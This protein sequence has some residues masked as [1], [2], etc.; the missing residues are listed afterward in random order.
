MFDNAGGFDSAVGLLDV[1]PVPD[2]VP[3]RLFDPPPSFGNCDPSG[4]L[5]LELDTGTADP[6]WLSDG[7][8]VEAIVG[9]DRVA[10]WAAARQARLL[11]E[12]A[13]R[14]PPDR[15]VGVA[16]TAGVASEFAPDEVGVAL[17][18]SRGTAGARIDQAVR[19][20]ST[21]P[22]THAAWEA[23]RIDT[24]K[25]RAIHDATVVVPDELAVAVEARVLPR[26]PGQ[27]LAQ[28]KAALG[29]AVPSVD[30][31]GADDRHREARRDRRV[32]VSPEP[33]GMASLWALLPATDAAG[34]FTWLTRLA[35]GLGADDP[36]CVDARRA[37]ILAALL[38]GRLVA[39]P[40]RPCEPGTS[41]APRESDEPGG[42][43]E[44]G[45]PITPV[46][47]G[48]P[49]IQVVIDHDTLL[50]AAERP[51]ELVGYGPIPA[52]L[53][54]EAAAADGLWRRLAVDPL[55]GTAL[56][57]GRTTYHPPAALADFV[58]VR[59]LTCRFP[60]CRRSARDAEL[61]HARAWTDG[62]ETSAANLHALCLH[63]HLLKHHA[64]WRITTHAD[65][66]LTWTTPTGLEHTT[67]PHDY[68]F[69]APPIPIVP[70]ACGPARDDTDPD[71]PPF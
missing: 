34:A 4:F 30:P 18:L 19:L 68:Q 1:A 5:A 31:Q 6:A 44:S 46:T 70:P 66:R 71:P 53:A 51:G 56:D 55:S 64:G 7:E 27:T 35:R 40:D 12:L 54:R 25:V 45:R 42:P 43:G 41:G 11:A 37:D 49:L 20:L 16:R 29:R 59:D 23:G 62:G 15:V 36:R 22:A 17:R 9:F 58:R 39:D 38:T 69:D 24:A 13:Q 61:D 52:A 47:P 32:V 21:L 28:L 2:E 33:D 65:G 48:K 10:S 14:R 8:L 26:A 63:H 67:A 50:G 57:Y 3:D 60:G